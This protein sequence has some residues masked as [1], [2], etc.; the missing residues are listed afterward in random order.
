METCRSILTN[1]P[2]SKRMHWWVSL[3]S[4]VFILAEEIQRQREVKEN[5]L[6]LRVPA[7]RFERFFSWIWTSVLTLLRSITCRGLIVW[8]LRISRRRKGCPTSL[9]ALHRYATNDNA[10]AQRQRQRQ[11]RRR[12]RRRHSTTIAHTLSPVFVIAIHGAKCFLFIDFRHAL[13]WS[14]AMLCFRV[15]FLINQHGLA[16]HSFFTSSSKRQVRLQSRWNKRRTGE[17]PMCS[18]IQRH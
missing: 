5:R 2:I 4:G 3:N 18:W 13:M 11:Q 1:N 12:R 15:S 7:L 6:L 14:I 17:R 8:N 9:M 10:S 16:T